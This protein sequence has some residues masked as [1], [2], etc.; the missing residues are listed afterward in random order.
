MKA[1]QAA[2]FRTVD[3]IGLVLQVSFPANTARPWGNA[4]PSAGPGR[5]GRGLGD[6]PRR[7]A[8]VALTD[9][10]QRLADRG[11]VGRARLP[12]HAT[13]VEVLRGVALLVVVADDDVP[14]AAADERADLAVDLMN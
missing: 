9:A 14:A 13:V 1:L 3:H 7:G 2:P 10:A 6:H 11:A 8:G 5:G 12:V 4:R